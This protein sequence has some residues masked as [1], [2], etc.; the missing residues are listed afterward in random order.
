MGLLLEA[1]WNYPPDE[2][3]QLLNLRGKPE[4]FR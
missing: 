3:I 2:P 1:A 4:R